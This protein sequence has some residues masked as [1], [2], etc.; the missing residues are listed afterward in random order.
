MNMVEGNNTWFI[1]SN[2]DI[3]RYLSSR[4]LLGFPP[5]AQPTQG[6]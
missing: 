5:F 6:T 2:L 1:H 4:L 3:N